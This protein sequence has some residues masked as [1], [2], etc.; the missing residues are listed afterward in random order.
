MLHFSQQ[1]VM[2]AP[3]CQT[4]GR[5]RCLNLHH[6]AGGGISP[7]LQGSVWINNR[8]RVVQSDYITFD[9]VIHH[10]STLLTPYSLKEKPVQQPNKVAHADQRLRINET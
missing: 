7:S 4:W 8:S 3:V 9:G 2:A 5:F 6:W 1:Q 10:V